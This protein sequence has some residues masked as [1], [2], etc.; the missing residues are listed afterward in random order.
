[1][2]NKEESGETVRERSVV[3]SRVYIILDTRVF[4]S[5]DGYTE[6]YLA[7]FYRG[8]GRLVLDLCRFI[9]NQAWNCFPITI[10]LPNSS[11]SVQLVHITSENLYSLI[12]LLDPK[13]TSLGGNN[14]ANNTWSYFLTDAMKK[15]RQHMLSTQVSQQNGVIQHAEIQKSLIL[16]YSTEIALFGSFSSG[17]IADGLEVFKFACERLLEL[18]ELLEIKITCFGLSSPSATR[19]ETDKNMVCNSGNSDQSNNNDFLLYEQ[20]LKD[21]PSQKLSFDSLGCSVLS[22]DNEYKGILSKIIPKK[23]LKLELPSFQSVDCSILIELTS[24]S[25]EGIKELLELSSFEICS[26]TTRNGINPLSLGG[27]TMSMNAVIEEVGKKCLG[28]TDG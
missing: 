21:F 25:I 24:H 4:P 2:Q 3:I 17:T 5:I 1:M 19:K 6:A 27:C 23:I 11:H 16:G 9:L 26:L 22:F 10:A 14:D 7:S 12:P 20:I 15:I 13:F 18:N 28:S 8:I